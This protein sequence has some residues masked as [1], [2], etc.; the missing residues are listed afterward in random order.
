MFK[1]KLLSIFIFMLLF[2]VSCNRASTPFI[3]TMMQNIPQPRPNEFSSYEA[4]VKT[5]FNAEN[6]NSFD[7]AL[8]CFPIVEHFEAKDINTYFNTLGMYELNSDAPIPDNPERNFLTVFQS[9]TYFWDEYRLKALVGSYPELMELK[10]TSD[11]QDLETKLNEIKN[12]KITQKYEDV[13]II[14]VLDYQLSPLLQGMGINETKV[15]EVETRIN[16]ET[17]SSSI[18]VGKID[19]NWRITHMMSN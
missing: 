8:K 6:E 14:E 1:L 2:I 7:D 11:T 12:M 4:V 18:T 19:G 13:K 16:N 10:L 9:Y 3:D 15:L 5:F 17:I